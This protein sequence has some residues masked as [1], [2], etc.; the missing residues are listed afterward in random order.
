[1]VNKQKRKHSHCDFRKLLFGEVQRVVDGGDAELCGFGVRGEE[2]AQDGVVG[3]V[4]EGHH[5][6]PAF[7]IIPDLTEESRG[8]ST[9]FTNF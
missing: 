5:G 4:H 1:M 2:G 3:H 8:Y 7:V 6:V 9:H